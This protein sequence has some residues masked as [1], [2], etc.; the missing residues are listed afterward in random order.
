MLLCSSHFRFDVDCRSKWTIYSAFRCSLLFTPIIIIIIIKYF[1]K[2]NCLKTYVQLRGKG[3]YILGMHICG[4]GG[5]SSNGS[6]EMG[7]MIASD[8]FEKTIR[9]RLAYSVL[10]NPGITIVG[11][12]Q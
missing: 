3:V 9:K 7:E 11:D 6:G 8:A 4:G 5:S 10:S 12:W 1:V 2:S